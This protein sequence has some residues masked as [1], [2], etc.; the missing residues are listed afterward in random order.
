[1]FDLNYDSK[2][3]SLEISEEPWLKDGVRLHHQWASLVFAPVKR[4]DEVLGY[5]V[6]IQPKKDRKAKYK[7][8]GGGR[9]PG[10][11]PLVTAIRELWGETG[12]KVLPG[13]VRYVNAEPRPGHWSILFVADLTEQD[14]P[15]MNTDHPENDGEIPRFF[16]VAEFSTLIVHDGFF[17][18]HLNRLRR[19]SLLSQAGV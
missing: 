8:P 11:T 17:E 1:M 3:C 14:V 16:T 12:I 4:V 6:V 9:E 5:V 10:E 7:L 15:W 2:R 19:F 13:V 18:P